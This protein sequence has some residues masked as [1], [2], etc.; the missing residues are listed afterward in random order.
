M[1]LRYIGQETYHSMTRKYYRKADV[2]LLCYKC[3]DLESFDHMKQY[4]KTQ[5]D[6]YARD[7]VILCIV[8]CQNDRRN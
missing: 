6:E 5:I 4:W 3:G 1:F 7:D 2:I 8:G